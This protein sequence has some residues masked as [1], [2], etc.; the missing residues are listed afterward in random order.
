MR[1]RLLKILTTNKNIIIIITREMRRATRLCMMLS[2]LKGKL[3]KRGKTCSK[4]SDTASSVMRT[5]LSCQPR[6]MLMC[7][8]LNH[9][10]WRDF[11]TNSMSMRMPLERTF[12]SILSQESTVIMRNFQV[13][14]S[15]LRIPPTSWVFSSILMITRLPCCKPWLLDHQ[16]RTLTS[17]T[18][19]TSLFTRRSSMRRDN[20]ISN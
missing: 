1:T 17:N 6:R 13:L 14:D 20:S 19:S 3:L 4:Q 2:L 11:L 16:S 8:K 7:R 12:R 9:S 15:M 18:R 5:C 10:L